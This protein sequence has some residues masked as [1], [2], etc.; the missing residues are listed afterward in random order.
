MPLSHSG[1]WNFDYRHFPT[2]SFAHRVGVYPP[3]FSLMRPSQAVL[4]HGS[5]IRQSIYRQ[6]LNAGSPFFTPDQRGV[7]SSPRCDSS[8]TPAAPPKSPPPRQ[9]TAHPPTTASATRTH[10]PPDVARDPDPRILPLAALVGR[11]GAI[12]R[13][14]RRRTSIWIDGQGFG[15]PSNSSIHSLIWSAP[16]PSLPDTP[17]APE[18]ISYSAHIYQSPPAPLFGLLHPSIS[19]R[20]FPM[21]IL[22]AL[23]ST[24]RSTANSPDA[25]RTSMVAKRGPQPTTPITRRRRPSCL[26]GVSSSMFEV[27]F[28]DIANKYPHAQI[29]ISPPPPCSH[30]YE[31]PMYLGRRGEVGISPNTLHPTHKPTHPKRAKAHCL[32]IYRRSYFWAVSCF[33]ANRYRPRPAPRICIRLDIANHSGACTSARRL[34]NT[35]EDS[36]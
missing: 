10:L 33:S 1:T 31:R 4:A 36:A 19:P 29:R 22:F 28:Y 3:R 9:T 5:D 30:F 14:F 21:G 25:G 13:I 23:D 12:A 34:S 16:M 27:D 8:Q 35:A 7:D 18:A 26:P 24:R 6:I 32:P 17:P 11:M 15:A 2:R 20:G